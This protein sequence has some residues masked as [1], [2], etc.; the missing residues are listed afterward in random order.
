MSQVVVNPRFFLRYSPNPD[1]P[2]L[3]V[4]EGIVVNEDLRARDVC[5]MPF[6]LCAHAPLRC[7]LPTSQIVL[8]QALSQICLYNGLAA[9]I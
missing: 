4:G 6:A 8:V 3:G 2:N 9:D 1:G 7:G 5:P